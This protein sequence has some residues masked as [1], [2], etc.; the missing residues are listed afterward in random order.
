MQDKKE[1]ISPPEVS[2]KDPNRNPLTVTG[3]HEVGTPPV[4]VQNEA[5]AISNF[6]TGPLC[7]MFQHMAEYS[8]LYLL[9]RRKG[10]ILHLSHFLF[11]AVDVSV[12]ALCVD[13]T[14]AG[15]V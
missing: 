2:S 3:V 11:R 14:E 6:G 13:D 10:A 7:T 8:T 5:S 4:R 1:V 9:G 15:F 12:E